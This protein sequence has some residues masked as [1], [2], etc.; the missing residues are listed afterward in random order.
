MCEAWKEYF[1]FAPDY[2]IIIDEIFVKNQTVMITGHA[3][4]TFTGDGFIDPENYW[5][6][7]AAWK[8]EIEDNLI[9]VWHLYANPEPME[10]IRTK[11]GISLSE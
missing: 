8:V 6:I 4:G 10:E 5:E 2:K 1:A 3:T 9:A 11:M 7:P